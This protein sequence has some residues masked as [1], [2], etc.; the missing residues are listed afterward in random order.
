MRRVFW[1]AGV[2]IAVLGCDPATTE[3]GPAPIAP[4]PPA[5]PAPP[6]VFSLSGTVKSAA[7]TALVGARVAITDGLFRTRETATDSSGYFSFS[8]VRGNLLLLVTYHDYVSQQRELVVTA[9]QSLTIVMLK[10]VVFEIGQEYS[11]T[12][13]ANAAP[14]DP[15]FWDA[16]AP[17]ARVRFLATHSGLLTVDVTWVSAG[18]V[19][20]TIMS[21]DGALLAYSG[22]GY[23]TATARYVVVAGS[24]YE[25]WIH[26][27]YGEASFKMRAVITP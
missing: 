11:S 23:P 5:P 13:D 6:A 12:I 9:S 17:C 14:C 18:D 2:M 19:D 20:F 22:A 15:V 10:V 27:Y 1:I 26:S 4:G 7:G 16:S 24:Y 8:D 25:I 3:P 21:D